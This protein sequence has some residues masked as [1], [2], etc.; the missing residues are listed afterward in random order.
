MKNKLPSILLFCFA[1]AMGFCLGLD[2]V[3]SQSTVEDPPAAKE[4]DKTE[5]QED[6]KSDAPSE[7]DQEQ[8]KSDDKAESDDQDKA[9]SD[10][11][12]DNKKEADDEEEADNSNEESQE[13]TTRSRNRRSPASLRNSK[14]NDNFVEMFGPV[15]SAA[16]SS[17]ARIY[18]G[19]R[20]VAF[21]AIVD[22]KGFIVTKASELRDNINCKLA[23][24][25]RYDAMV[26]GIDPETDLALLK[27][28]GSDFDLQSIEWAKNP[29]PVIGRWV[30]TP[31]QESEAI[32][33][34]VVSVNERVITASRPFIGIQMEETENK[35]GV[36]INGV[37]P[38]S[39][40]DRAG[41]LINDI[42]IKLDDIE[43]AEREN[44]VESLGQYSIGDVATLTILRKKE[45]TKVQI[46]LGDRTNTDPQ[47]DRSNQQNSMG[48]TRS[49]RRKDFPL[50]FQHD[51]AFEAK[52]CGGPI[53]DL[54]G[55]VIGINIANDTRPSAL[56]LPKSIV[57]PVVKK[58]M[59]GDYS[60]ALVNAERIK[61]VSVQLD[62]LNAKTT[63]LN[64]RNLEL[65]KKVAVA[66]ARKEEL[67][68]SLKE[69]QERLKILDEKTGNSRSELKTAENE[70]KVAKSAKRRLESKRKA[71]Q[72]VLAN[73]STSANKTKGPANWQ[74]PFFVGH[75][76]A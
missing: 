41:L 57:E 55:K 69:I 63:K 20:H 28:V 24:G 22:P 72:Q 56:A 76:S 25:K 39:A 62:D 4:Q 38:G 10:D 45:E 74:A 50:A 46:I 29:D 68:K 48:S 26:Y 73:R 47:F 58:L 40:A 19:K 2:N 61:K 36:R 32:A 37:V 43:V 16:S 12:S 34:G 9:E 66:D 13:S 51:S 17:T 7:S 15:I 59:S 54:S 75:A 49:K 18:G 8:S 70:L 64:E 21:G 3:H 52:Y 35:S 71:W 14:R 6:E 65:E 44:L 60:P 33:V 27:L 30:I 42:V 67:E 5:K 1:F 23:D 53:V 31:N 11:K